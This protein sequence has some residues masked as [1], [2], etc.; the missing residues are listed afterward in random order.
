MPIQPNRVSAS[1]RDATREYQPPCML[2]RSFLIRY[3]PDNK[4]LWAVFLEV[5]RYLSPLTFVLVGKRL[6]ALLPCPPA[7]SRCSCISSVHWG[8]KAAGTSF[9]DGCSLWCWVQCSASGLDGAAAAVRPQCEGISTGREGEAAGEALHKAVE[10]TRGKKQPKRRGSHIAAEPD[11]H[12]SSPAGTH[13]HA[14]G[15]CTLSLK[16]QT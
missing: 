7:Q 14:S 1:S 3:Q 15:S 13:R 9:M 4:G 6:P 12:P 10:K 2:K 16:L 5:L 8:L 11:T